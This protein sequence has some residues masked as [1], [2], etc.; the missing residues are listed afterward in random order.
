MDVRHVAHNMYAKWRSC[1]ILRILYKWK[2]CLVL[3]HS[4]SNCHDPRFEDDVDLEEKKIIANDKTLTRQEDKNLYCRKPKRKN[5]EREKHGC[6]EQYKSIKTKMKI[7]E[8]RQAKWKYQI[9]MSMTGVESL[10]RNHRG[11][12][13]LYYESKYMHQNILVNI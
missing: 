9:D 5:K 8:R 2:I 3:N 12:K 7:K 6:Q 4:G 11:Y 1:T 13:Y 10:E